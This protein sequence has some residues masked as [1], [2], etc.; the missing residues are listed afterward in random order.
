MKHIKDLVSKMV[1]DQLIQQNKRIAKAAGTRVT[2][3]VNRSLNNSTKKSQ[4]GQSKGG[5]SL[6]KKS[7]GHNSSNNTRDH[8]RGRPRSRSPSRSTSRD[9]SRTTSRSPSKR[10]QPS[11][12]RSNQRQQPKPG[13]G[14]GQPQGGGLCRGRFLGVV[15]VHVQ[16]L[17]VAVGCFW[18]HLV[19]GV[20][21]DCGCWCGKCREMCCV[22][23]CGSEVCRERDRVCCCCRCGREISF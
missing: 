8:A 23:G 2:Q 19:G 3:A 16:A 5:A 12:T 11:A 15:R 1:Q 14:R 4:R 18:W 17:F 10:R 20:W 22:M 7:P 9:T 6:K 13:R 21:R